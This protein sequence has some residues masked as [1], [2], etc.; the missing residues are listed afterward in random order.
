M[1]KTVL[2]NRTSISGYIQTLVLSIPY[3]AILCMSPT[4]RTTPL[5][6]LTLSSDYLPVYYQAVQGASPT[7]SGIDILSITFTV[8]PTT[9]LSGIYIS[10]YKSCRLP[11]WLGW[12][13][14][15][16][17]TGLLT[18]L[19]TNSS[20]AASIGYPALIG[21]GIGLI[22]SSLQFPILAPLDVGLNARAL[23]LQIFLRAFSQTWGIAIGGA[24][25]QSELVRRLPASV[26][27]TDAS[28]SQI[29]FALIPS[30]PSLPQAERDAVRAAFADSLSVAWWILFGI[31]CVGLV[32]SLAMGNHKMAEKVDQKWQAKNEGNDKQVSSEEGAVPA[33]DEKIDEW[34]TITSLEPANKQ[35]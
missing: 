21:V 6:P 20:R 23:S 14:L 8:P 17:G 16:I 33:D 2:S 9:I 15:T 3:N 24:V 18:F 5:K 13:L 30:I 19:D 22:F 35:T 10:H 27:P 32:A 25:L 12:I 31:T 29:A 7:Q 28:R 26:I 4:I 11:I 1:P 34:V